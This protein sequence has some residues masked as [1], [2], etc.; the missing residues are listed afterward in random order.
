MPGESVTEILVGFPDR[1]RNHHTKKYKGKWQCKLLKCDRNRM[2]FQMIDQTF[3]FTKGNAKSESPLITVEI[4][5]SE[6]NSSV[7][8]I[9]LKWQ[10][11]VTLS[12]N[13]ISAC[14]RICDRR[15]AVGVACACRGFDCSPSVPDMAI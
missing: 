15:Q 3:D 7:M 5:D 13:F 4:N 8:D 12:N 2:V 14:W 6:K 11:D 1:Y 9:S 10:K